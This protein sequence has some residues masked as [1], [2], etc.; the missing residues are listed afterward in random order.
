MIQVLKEKLGMSEDGAK[1]L[2]VGSIYN[3]FYYV[4]LMLP[5]SVLY[6]FI[7]DALTFLQAS[8]APAFRYTAYLAVTGISIAVSSFLYYKQYNAVFFTVYGETEVKRLA[9]G[10]KLRKLPL[11]FFEKKD[12]SDLANT[13]LEDVNT[14][15][16]VQSHIIPGMAGAI[17]CS[18]AVS[19]MMIVWDWRMGLAL[20]WVV[21]VVLLITAMSGRLQKKYAARHYESKRAVAEAAQENLEHIADISAYSL[22]QE[23]LEAYRQTVEK[24]EKSH[25]TAELIM[26]L[27]VS[28]GQ[29]F[30]KLGFA[31]TM[32]T[33]A[34]LWERGELPLIKYLFYL[35]GSAK[36]YDP[37]GMILNSASYFYG[38]EAPVQ[39]MNDISSRR[40][41][42][43]TSNFTLTNFDIEFENVTFGYTAEKPAINGVGFTAEQGKVTALTG[44]SG[45]GKSTLAKLAARFYDVDSGCIKI[46][47][48]D[49]KTLDPEKLMAYISMVFQET[50]LF[51]NTVMENIRIGKKGADDEAVMAA[52]KLAHAHEF[53]EQLPHGY[54]TLIGENGARLS[55][56]ERLRLSIARALLKDAPILLL[57]EATSALDVDNESAVQE[58]LSRLIKGK[59]VLIIAHRMRTV[60][61]ADKIV[62]L[63]SGAIAETGSPADLKQADGLFQKMRSV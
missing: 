29:A 7:E 37:I 35:I 26:S 31:T 50:V 53:I 18:A 16:T 48:T 40:P 25:Q 33:G 10:E 63:N 14:I 17:G 22:E 58:S 12:L 55:G 6:L 11:S 4:S 42:E 43:G 49:I 46:G 1:G 54:Q 20:C 34:V 30:L 56:G 41:M 27:F 24:E 57:D 44:H 51:D 61:N 15:E 21:P 3:I 23:Y 39:R 9:L 62:V 59:T 45:S 8:T 47:G 13:I 36:V 32:I 52:A 19:V 60:E 5:M 38:M 28:G 2:F